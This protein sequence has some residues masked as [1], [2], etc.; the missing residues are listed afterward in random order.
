MTGDRAAARSAVQALRR[1]HPWLSMDLVLARFH[2]RPKPA[3]LME[4]LASSGL[5]H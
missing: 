2:H 3:R 1:A 4:A 5:P